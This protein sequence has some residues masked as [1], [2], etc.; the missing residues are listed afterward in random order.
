MTFNDFLLHLFYLIDS[1]LAAMNLSRLRQRGHRPLLHDSEVITI[2]V[3][4][5]FL[6]IDTDKGIYQHF[7]R[8][9]L[10]EFPALARIDRTTFVRQSAN[11]WR[12]KQLLQQRLMRQLP[13]SDPVEGTPLWLVDSFPLRVCRVVRA[14]FSKL[15]AAFASFGR[16]PAL[17]GR[18]CF[19]GFRVHLCLAAEIGAIAQV[20]IAP[21]N[22]GDV[23][24]VKEIAP[25]AGGIGIGDRNYWSPEHQQR[26]KRD[27]YFELHAAYRQKSRDPDPKRSVLLGHLRQSAEV[28]IGHLAERFHAER[29]WAR[30]LWHLCSRLARKVLSHTAALLLNWLHGNPPLQLSRLVTA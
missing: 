12:I 15:F 22:V 6:G 18:H 10:S 17:T 5:E 7:R 26:L 20:Q 29:T 23:L 9:H 27:Q 21:A 16:D 25:V 1:E 4:G 8:Y 28:S 13:L 19:F 3:A 30:D 14:R 11:L 24:L 2:E